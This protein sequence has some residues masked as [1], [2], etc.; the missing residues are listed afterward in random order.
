MSTFA[1]WCTFFVINSAWQLVFL[2]AVTALLVRVSS[3]MANG[4]QYRLWVGC[5]MLAVTL[6]V[7]SAYLALAPIHSSPSVSQVDDANRWKVPRQPDRGRLTMHLTE[8][9]VAHSNWSLFGIIAGLYIACS[10][11]GMGR[12]LLRLDRTRRIV[13]R[14]APLAFGIADFDVLQNRLTDHKRTVEVFASSELEGP[15]TVNW[16]QPMILLPPAFDL[17]AESEKAAVVAHELAHVQR[18]DFETNLLFEALSSVLCY[19]PA[20]PWLKRRIAECREAMCDEMAAEA[21]FGRTAYARSL[22]NVAQRTAAQA[23]FRTSLSLGISDTELERRIMKLVHPPLVISNRRRS[24]LHAL[25]LLSLALSSVGILYFSLHPPTVQAAGTP[26]FPFDPS[27]TFDTLTPKTQ[28]KQ[29]PDFTLVDNNGKAVTLSNYKGKVVLLDFWATWCGGCKLEI[30][31]YMGFD[32]KYRKDGLAVIGVSMDDK[33]WEVVRPFLAK[34]KDDETG[35]MIAMQY[36]IVIGNDALGSQFG[37][38]SMPMTLLIDKDGKI[39][40]S[41]TGVVDKDNFENNIRELLK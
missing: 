18:R 13:A 30:P 9:P 5:L 23:S 22:L 12:L 40:L 29:A 26:A 24:L 4:L 33:G 7:I 32:R 35:G 25:C 21:T 1:S 20:T 39:A 3:K 37:L 27:Q 6:P 10:V 14:R 11:F 16:P 19:H 31:W 36:P 28:R 2:A 8:V 34:K 41:H 38:T 17:M 15:A